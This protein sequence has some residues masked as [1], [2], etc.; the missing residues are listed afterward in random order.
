[1][2]WRCRRSA[3]VP[4]VSAAASPSRDAAKRRLPC[5]SCL[6]PLCKQV[7]LHAVSHQ[8]LT[9]CCEAD[10]AG[11]VRPHAQVFV[12]IGRPR[13][14][15]ALAA[16]EVVPAACG[17]SLS[18]WSPLPSCLDNEAQPASW[19]GYAPTTLLRFGRLHRSPSQAAFTATRL[20][21]A[22][23][24]LAGMALPEGPADCILHLHLGRTLTASLATVS[25]PE[26]SA[27]AGTAAG[28]R[29]LATSTGHSQVSSRSTSPSDCSTSV[30]TRATSAC[31]AA[32]RGLMKYM[33][34]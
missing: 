30:V 1:M 22:Q 8:T 11:G 34:H 19:A 15:H 26:A 7:V 20:R 23:V 27:P 12:H 9:Y 2:G 3:A 10:E 13:P 6:V 28:C 33:N 5:E 31:A 17:S 32:S 29:P 14:E 18:T 4:G 21:S 24:Q 25:L 16:A